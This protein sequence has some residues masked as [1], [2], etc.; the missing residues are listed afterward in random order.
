MVS[1]LWGGVG[2]WWG[3]GWRDCGAGTWPSADPSSSWEPRPT[4]WQML[5]RGGRLWVSIL[6]CEARQALI[7]LGWTWDPCARRT[8]VNLPG[9]ECWGDPLAPILPSPKGKEDSHLLARCNRNC[10]LPPS[11]GLQNSEPS[12][13]MKGWLANHSENSFA[14]AKQ[15]PQAPSPPLQKGPTSVGSCLAGAGHVPPWGLGALR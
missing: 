2:S 8:Q 7:A 9:L 1:L 13:E 6:G 12:G 15:G 4:P 14:K 11:L 3:C 10:H 5:Q